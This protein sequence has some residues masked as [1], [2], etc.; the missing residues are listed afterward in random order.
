MREL[1]EGF[2]KLNQLIMQPA[3]IAFRGERTEPMP[4]VKSDSEIEDWIRATAS[5]DYHPSCSCRMGSDE[6]SVVDA[7]LR[8]HGIDGLRGP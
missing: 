8:V 5:T 3:F 7:E 4:E 1:V 2:H 6:S